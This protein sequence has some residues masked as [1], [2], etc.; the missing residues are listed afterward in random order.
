MMSRTC[1]PRIGACI[2]AIFWA[3]AAAAHDLKISTEVLDGTIIATVAYED[4][5]IPWQ[6]DVVISTDAEPDLD[7]LVTDGRGQVSIPLS[8]AAEGVIIEASDAEGHFTYVILTP[9]D[10]E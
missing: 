7:R 1:T 10:L 2:L 9:E 3:S 4:G 6:A 5:A 8:V